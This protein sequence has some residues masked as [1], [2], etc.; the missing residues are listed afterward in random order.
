MY[1]MFLMN[2]R[3]HL[4][5]R[6]PRNQKYHYFPMFLLTQ[7]YLRFLMNHLFLYFPKSLRFRYFQMYQKNLT[8]Q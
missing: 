8:F 7:N 3:F 4:T 1:Q 5:R 2:L 6:C